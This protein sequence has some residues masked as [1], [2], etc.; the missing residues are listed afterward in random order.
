VQCDVYTDRDETQRDGPPRTRW[1]P[2][3][4][5]WNQ[6]ARPADIAAVVVFL[7]ADG[8]ASVT[9]TFVTIDG[10]RELARSS[11]KSRA[12]LNLAR[13]S[14]TVSRL[15]SPDESQVAARCGL[16]HRRAG[17]GRDETV[18]HHT[19]HGPLEGSGGGV[20]G[21]PGRGACDGRSR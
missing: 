18:R 9:S 13:T 21:S 4:T 12:L 20:A 19:A 1:T 2:T 15:P 7:A 11:L 6:K 10:G 17:E 8:A 3:T 14:H 16:T 5:T